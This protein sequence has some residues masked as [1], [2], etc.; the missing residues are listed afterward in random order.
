MLKDITIGQYFA[1]DSLIHRLDP[2]IK[3]ILTML[4]IAMVFIP[5]N[6]A[7]LIAVAL[8]VVAC[9]GV[10]GI[11]LSTVRRSLKPICCPL[12]FLP[13]SSTSF[14]IEGRVLV[15]LG[16]VQITYEGLLV[17]ALMVLRIV[18]LIAGT[19]LTYTTSP[20]ALTDAI[21]RLLPP[22]GAWVCLCTSWP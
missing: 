22:C 3:L 20:I 4:Y 14:F 11:S 10:S 8:F 2:R 7:G 18:C 5:T 21:E 15:N 17:S 12:W 13:P 1:G 9:Y 19:S 16:F 6:P